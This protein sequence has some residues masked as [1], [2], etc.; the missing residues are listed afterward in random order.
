MLREPR[1][2]EPE[3]GQTSYVGKFELWAR[4]PPSG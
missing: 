4:V 2:R 3:N 1:Q